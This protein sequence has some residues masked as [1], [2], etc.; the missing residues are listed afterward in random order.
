M[1]LYMPTYRHVHMYGYVHVHTH[2]HTQT[3]YSNNILEDLTFH[4]PTGLPG[5][6]IEVSSL[7]VS[8]DPTEA[9]LHSQELTERLFL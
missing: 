2:T 4:L 9:E 1:Y 8:Y 5:I 6:G 3:Y 7:V